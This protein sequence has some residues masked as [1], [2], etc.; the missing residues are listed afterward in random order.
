MTAECRESQWLHEL[1]GSFGHDDVD[2]ESLALKFANQLRGLVG[3]DA[4]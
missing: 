3:S 2:F 4:T 1:A